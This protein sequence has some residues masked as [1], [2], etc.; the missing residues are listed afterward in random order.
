VRPGRGEP[1]AGGV[2]AVGHK[3]R[4]VAV[5]SLRQVGADG[6]LGLGHQV[7]ATGVPAFAGDGGRAA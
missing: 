1:A 3:E 4:R 6:R 7:Q 5:G 2:T